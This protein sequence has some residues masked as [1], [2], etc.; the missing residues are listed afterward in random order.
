MAFFDHLRAAWECTECRR[1]RRLAAV[2]V[3]LCIVSW[4]ML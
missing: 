2:F 4:L 3:T 1:Y